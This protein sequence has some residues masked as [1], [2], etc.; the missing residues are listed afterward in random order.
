MFT[1]I[2]VHLLIA[3]ITLPLGIWL[4]RVIHTFKFL[5]NNISE[6]AIAVIQA[7]LIAYALIYGIIMTVAT[8]L[9]NSPGAWLP[10]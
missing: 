6:N 9:L 4:K 8:M 5:R 2:I 1:Y 10:F 7:L 3:I